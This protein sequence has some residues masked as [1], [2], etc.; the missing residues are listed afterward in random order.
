MN[1]DRED[2]QE[3]EAMNLEHMLSLIWGMWRE[4][5]LGLR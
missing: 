2:G 4:E 5:V 3:R 1:V